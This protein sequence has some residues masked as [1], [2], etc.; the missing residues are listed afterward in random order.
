MHNYQFYYIY[1][2]IYRNIFTITLKLIGHNGFLEDLPVA[3]I[4]KT[5]G[6][7]STKG[8]TFRIHTLK[9]LGPIGLNVEYGI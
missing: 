6:S 4:Y 1:R 9:T 7:Y 8:E 2:N 5:D 3:L